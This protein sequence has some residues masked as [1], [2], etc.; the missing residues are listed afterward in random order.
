MNWEGRT[1]PQPSPAITT[2]AVS[3]FC[4]VFAQYTLR[5]VVKRVFSQPY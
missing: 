4:T 2:L 1:P 3:D 5:T